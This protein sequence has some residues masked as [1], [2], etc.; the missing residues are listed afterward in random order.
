MAENSAD[1]VIAIAA[2][3]EEQSASSD[4]MTSSISKINTFAINNESTMREA[5]VAIQAMQSARNRLNKALEYIG[6]INI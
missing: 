4:E 1:Q 2:A 3:A 6:T 5:K